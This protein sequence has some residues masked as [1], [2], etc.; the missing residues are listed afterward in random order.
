MEEQTYDGPRLLRK[1]TVRDITGLT[2]RGIADRLAAGTFPKPVFI[3]ARNSAWIEV[4]VREW[5]AK[6]VHER[7][8]EVITPARAALIES[9]RVGGQKAQQKR[10]EAAA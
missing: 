7:D 8:N 4:E 2:D 6:R 3:D 5:I 1:A 10:R 9:R